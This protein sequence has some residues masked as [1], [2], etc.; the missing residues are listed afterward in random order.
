MNKKVTGLA[1]GLAV[2]ISVI[3]LVAALSSGGGGGA[4]GAQ[5][6][7]TQ[8]GVDMVSKTYGGTFDDAV[9]IVAPTAN[10]TADAALK[11]NSHG[12]NAI[13]SVQDAGTDVFAIYDGGQVN[14]KVLY[15]A[16]ANQ[17]LSCGTSTFTATATVADTLSTPLYA[18]CSVATD[19]GESTGEICTTAN[20]SGVI[21]VKTWT[22]AGGTATAGA[23]AETVNWCI[24]GTP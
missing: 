8:G 22:L 2:L 13:L 6:V 20:A 23:A 11:V 9:A 4:F 14:G 19:P 5:S 12:V 17:E 18:F 10:A 7:P 1:V 16:T 15:Y 24:V 21:T 3:A